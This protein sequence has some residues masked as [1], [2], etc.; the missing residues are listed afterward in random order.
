MNQ[1]RN[2]VRQGALRAAVAAT[3]LGL[4]AACGGGGGN[5]IHADQP[6]GRD[7]P[8][9]GAGNGSAAT[10]GQ[11]A[12]TDGAVEVSRD[13][14]NYVARRRVE[15]RNDFGGA[16]RADVTLTVPNGEVVALANGGGG[17]GMELVLEARAGS[18]ADARRGLDSISVTHSDALASGTLT[19][20][21]AVQ[22]AAL[23]AGTS[24]LPGGISI[25]GGGGSTTIERQASL[26]AGLPP[27]ASYALKPSASNGEVRVSGLSGSLADLDTA[28]GELTLNGRWDRARLSGS[29]S[30]VSVSGD[31]ADLDVGVS[32][33]F[34][35]AA[36]Q[37]RRS[38]SADFE[39]ANGEIDVAVE[40]SAGYDLVADTTSGSARI[41]VA[42]T[43]AV[44][45]QTAT[46]AHR[47]SSD[48]DSR[49]V[50]AQI[51]ASTTN[52]NID[53]HQ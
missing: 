49:A 44:G 22:F 19:L 26:V 28:N 36:L 10:H 43:V 51:G 1:H 29:N 39:T 18:E 13:G 52:G 34:I 12:R 3:L 47:R 17:Y 27:A 21:T 20:N 9:G 41:D 42:G 15:I 24:P 33:G 30:I 50:K 11:P 14:N 23:E 4:L 5:Q 35:E 25:G 6:T 8:S 7:A 45:E 32:N 2:S 46:S 16:S 38:L 40:G 48:Y 31:Y 53:I 37:V